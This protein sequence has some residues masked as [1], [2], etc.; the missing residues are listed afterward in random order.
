MWGGVD[1]L[2][3]PCRGNIPFRARFPSPPRLV[4]HP[5][6]YENLSRSLRLMRI[7]PDLS[8]PVPV[9]ERFANKYEGRDKSG[10]YGSSKSTTSFPY[11]QIIQ[12]NVLL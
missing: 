8:R 9:V 6:P 4:R 2:G 3:R 10:P 11:V 1:P 12:C 5:R 7:G